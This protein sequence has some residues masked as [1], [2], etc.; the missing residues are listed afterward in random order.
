ME[1]QNTTQAIGVD[2]SAVGGVCRALNISDEK[3]CTAVATSINGLFS[4]PPPYLS[5]SKKTL[6][7]YTFKD[8][9]TSSLLSEIHSHLFTKLQLLDRVIRARKLHNSRFYAWDMDY[10]HAKYLDYLQGMRTS[11]VAALG[12]LERRSA[13]VVYKDEKWWE[14][15]KGVQ[16][17]GGE[18]RKEE[19]EAKRIKDEAAMFRRHWKAAESRMRDNKRKEEAKRQDA[20]LDQVYRERMAEKARDGEVGEEDD[21]EMEWD[22][23][24]DVLE[25]NRGSYID[26]IQSFLWMAVLEDKVDEPVQQETTPPP[27][28]T[29]EPPTPIEEPEI[30]SPMSQ[31][32][33]PSHSSK[34]AKAKKKK[35]QT[36]SKKPAAAEPQPQEPDKTL[37]ESK[38]E[39]HERLTQGVDF[40]SDRVKGMLIAG[41]I[42][43]PVI[44]TKTITFPEDETA[45]L[46]SE[47]AEI[48]HLL[49]CRLVL[50]HAALLPAALRANSLDEFIADEEVTAGA[51]RDLCLK[52]ENPGLQEI[53]DAC[54]DLFRAD[55]EPE[56]EDVDVVMADEGVKEVHKYDEIFKPKKRKGE[57]PD[58]WLP[59]QEAKKDA[60]AM[61]AVPT[62]DTVIGSAEGGAVDF[63]KVEDDKTPRKK[64]RVKICGRSIWNYPSDKAMNRGGWLHFCIIAKDSDL[65]D[66][67]KLCRHWDEFFEL[68]I[69]AIWGY[70]PGKN[71]AEW[72]GNRYRQQM[73]QNGFIMYF[74]SHDPDARDLTVHHQKGGRR[75]P[76]RRA[77][78]AFEARNWICAHIKRD[79]QASRRLVQYLAM[80]RHRLL[81]LVRDAETGSLVIKPPEEERWLWRQKAGLGRASKNEWNVIKNVGPQFF[82]DMEKYRG[83]NFSF[84]EY[85]DVYVWDLEPG[86]CFP[87]LYNT[88]QEMIFKAL[89]CRKGADMYN[90]AAPILKT[91][92]TDKITNRV[93]D[94][95]PG[96]DV[97]SIYDDINHEGTK[98]FYSKI[99]DDTGLK[100][101]RVYDQ[102]NVFPPNLLYNEADVL[103]DA[104]L[105]PEELAA[106][107]LNPKD[108]GKISPLKAWEDEG[109]SLRKFIEGWESDYSG[110]DSEEDG[111]EW[112][113][114][115]ESDGEDEEDDD[116]DF[117]D[118][119][120]D[121]EYVFDHEL[122]PGD[123]LLDDHHSEDD[124]LPLGESNGKTFSKATQ[125]EII[126]RMRYSDELKAALAKMLNRP[127]AR[128]KNPSDPQV[129]EEEFMTFIDKEKAQ[130]FKQ[131]WHQADTTP[132][133]QAHYIEMLEMCRSSRKFNHR[134]FDC[135][136]TVLTF[137]L[138]ADMNI[139]TGDSKDLHRAVAKMTPFFHKEFFAPDAIGEPFKDSLI[140]NQDA[141][142]KEYPET[143][144]HRSNKMQPEAFWEEFD[145]EMGEVE[146]IWDLPPERDLA[147]RPIIAHLYKSGIIRSRDAHFEGQAISAVEPH[148]PNTPDFFIDWRQN[149]P[150][151]TMAPEV[152]DPHLV[153]PLLTFAS[154]F[155]S[156]HPAA[157]FAIL[158]LWSAP[159]FY[160]LMIGAQNRDGNSFRDL[161]GRTYNFMFVPKCMPFSEWSIHRAAT[162]RVEPWK[163]FFG[164]RVVVRRD[165]FL[166][167]GTDEKDL[168]RLASALTFAV[169]MRPWRLE[170]DLWR[171][172]VNL[173]VEFLKG[174]DGRWLQ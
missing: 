9:T 99:E 89:R 145:R 84:K 43:N 105:F 38:S 159:Y 41:T 88:V 23:I 162:L 115:S 168:F 147:I 109:F 149:I 24:E 112:R 56:E 78:M 69:L 32:I 28:P 15:V 7:S 133:A 51:L 27:T 110:E 4:T 148:R 96:E 50:G 100:V 114:D 61:G 111:M 82:E 143:R 144:S 102:P 44:T 172:W 165:K 167:M 152:K 155:A 125:A 40:E 21:D 77:H 75:G 30:T 46:L 70:F 126:S 158:T 31:P 142:A 67:V 166:V 171:S 53:R 141:R 134:T 169:Q 49:F 137:N 18:S 157:R 122:E 94:I 11:T 33:K 138:L 120:E 150:T 45:R 136:A 64:I 22:P 113:T 73:L 81:V 98:F 74:E 161:V 66:A 16:D 57:L 48:K 156:R 62:Y 154:S 151:V 72:A 2:R 13:E 93:R 129:M 160:P 34:K 174:L 19:K 135:P 79:D 163:K 29:Q 80:Q 116:D 153:P 36:P 117:D 127:K 3:Q 26:L 107:K 52:M 86:E 6:S 37:I 85:Y 76:S 39:M 121:G 123:V 68:N 60:A 106:D 25:D 8:I 103:E 83:W 92:H 118:E 139:D 54:A 170:V 10:G 132:H 164:D 108:I 87:V 35:S 101:H 14:W 65:H 12:R 104:I 124:G 90:L 58:K 63:G 59:K 119:D 1:K 95:K 131:V 17:E 91:L 42:E 47:I 146:G 128:K 140:F 20:Y 173:D 97:M 71:W 130:I 55:E 5:N